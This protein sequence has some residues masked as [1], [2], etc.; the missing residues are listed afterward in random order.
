MHRRLV[1]AALLL[2]ACSSTPESRV[3][4]LKA[5]DAGL[6]VD[7]DTGTLTLRWRETTLATLPRDAFQ[8]GIVGRLSD[9]EAYDPYWIYVDEP[10]EPPLPDGLEFVTP[11]AVTVKSADETQ[12]ELGLAFAGG[13]ATVTVRSTAAGRFTLQL[14][15]TTRTEG[16]VAY[17]RVHAVVDPAEAFYGLGEWADTPMHRGKVRPMQIEA[18]LGF[19]GA[20]DENHVPVPLLVGTKGWGLF[21]ESRRPGVFD[22]ASQDPTIVDTT[23]GTA[24]D[25]AAGLTVHLFAAAHPL[26]VTRRY[27]EV[28][29]DPLLPAEWAYGPWIWRDEN[30]NQAEVLD[31]VTK[32]RDLDLATSGIWIDRPYATGVNTFDFDATKFADPDAMIAN[33]HAAGLRLALWHTPYV[34]TDAPALR[35][36][37]TQRGFFPP[38]PGLSLNHWSAP[39]DLTN[40]EAFSWW[41]GLIRRYTDRGIEGFKLDYAEDVFASYVGSRSNWRFHDGSDERTMHSIYTLLYHKVYAET[42]PAT[43]G[44]LL[45][46]TGRWG[47]QRNVSV[48]WPGDLNASFHRYGEPIQLDN[49]TAKAVGGLPAAVSQALSLGPSGFPFYAS[50]TGGYRQSPPNEEV[51]VR[52]F[53]HTA[54]SAVMQVGDSSSQPPWVYTA[55]NGRDDDTLALYRTYARTHLQLFPYVWSHARRLAVDGRPIVRALGLAHPELGTHPA[56]VYLLGD[57][58]LVAPVVEAGVTS[59]TVTLPAGD[60]YSWWDGAKVSGTATLPAPLNRIPVMIRA[61]AMIPLLRPTIDT[62][63]PATLAGVESYANDPGELFVR[64]VP[65]TGGFTVYDDT[66]LEQQP[67]RITVTPGRTFTKGARLELLATTKPGSVTLDGA[68]LA[69]T[70]DLGFVER[71]WRF[72][73]PSTTWIKLPAAGGVATIAP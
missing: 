7:R 22:V 11:T 13:A 32:I 72:E 10:L 55:E 15:P 19:E 8:L 35:E 73:P 61:G 44:F 57:T 65:G 38:K 23:W 4:V 29:G 50:D 63:A 18:L 40:P 67:G 31:D 39:I 27:Y 25:S 36:E 20:S 16:V 53:Q 60:W 34:A 49:G 70:T 28:T 64:V 21:V 5:G 33:V 66:R 59:R 58:L 45:A 43:G 48:I 54:F 41:Q 68:P 17:M 47:D 2:V 30:E 62:L 71:G 12:A 69:E 1:A 51:Y 3:T 14:T 9:S 24:H 37:A 26:D 46:R 42:L 52:W 6:A 56:D